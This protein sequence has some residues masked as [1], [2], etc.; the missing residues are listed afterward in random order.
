MKTRKHSRDKCLAEIKI[1]DSHYSIRAT[2]H[3]LERMSQR[4]I[5]EY[6]VI[7][8]VLAL[9]EERLLTLQ[10]NNEEAIIIDEKT[11]T[12]VVISFHGNRIHVVTTIDKSNV[13]V[14]SG[15]RIE[16]L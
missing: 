4:N 5:D 15:T 13:Y 10:E 14:K 3:A 6:V 2:C 9:G 12:A 8:N 16:R 1:N 11:D 7:G